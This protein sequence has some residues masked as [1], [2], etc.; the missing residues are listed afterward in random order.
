MNLYI[1]SREAA[2]N[3]QIIIECRVPK[4][5]ANIC[6]A[7]VLINPVKAQFR[8]CW[9]YDEEVSGNLGNFITWWDG[10]TPAPFSPLTFRPL[11]KVWA[12]YILNRRSYH[13]G[14]TVSQRHTRRA[15]GDCGVQL[16]DTSRSGMRHATWYSIQFSGERLNGRRYETVN[17]NVHTQF[18]NWQWTVNLAWVNE[19]LRIGWNFGAVRNYQQTEKVKLSQAGTAILGCTWRLPFMS[20]ILQHSNNSY[21][22][23]GPNTLA[24]LSSI[25]HHLPLRANN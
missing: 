1:D 2:K 4:Y 9:L 25:Y 8:V 20:S 3:I 6:D 19:L 10:D 11:H 17:S 16:E 14:I 22:F 21:K 24:H 12:A 13:L 15:I 5:W 23:C 18:C 7:R